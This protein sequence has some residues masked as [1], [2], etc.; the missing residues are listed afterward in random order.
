MDKVFNR[1][2]QNSKMENAISIFPPLFRETEENTL[3][4]IEAASAIVWLSF[5][6]PNSGFWRG[7]G[8]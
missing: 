6:C 1:F 7:V 3:S 2:G 5:S 4:Q 8:N